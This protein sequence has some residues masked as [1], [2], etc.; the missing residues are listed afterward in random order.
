LVNTFYGH[1][2]IPVGIVHGGV[3]AEAFQKKFPST[4]WPTTRYTQLISQRKSS[5]G[6]VMYPQRLMD[7]A[8]APDAVALLRQTLAAQRDSSVV[9][10]QV[11]YS[12]NLARLLDSP[13]DAASPLKGRDLIRRKVRLLSV[14]AGNFGEIQAE[15]KTLAKGTA[16]FNLMVDVPAA[17]ALFT[18]WPTPIVASGFEIGLAMRFPGQ[19]IAHDFGYVA[20]HPIADT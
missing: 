11:G 1:A 17:Q 10:I 20:H 12:T 14:M 4:T 19:S 3:T 13:A 15:G 16:E 18:S 8:K 7:G 6:S 2:Q 5:D 9:L